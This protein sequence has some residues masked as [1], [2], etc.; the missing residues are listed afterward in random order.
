ME[1]Y[2]VEDNLTQCFIW[3]HYWIVG[4]EWTG[5]NIKK[6]LEFCLKSEYPE[7]ENQTTG[8]DPCLHLFVLI[9]VKSSKYITLTFF[10]H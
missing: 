10:S 5:E 4:I 7:L 3:R 1:Y 8:P 2:E 6:V 9:L